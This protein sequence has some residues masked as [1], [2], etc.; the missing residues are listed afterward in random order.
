[1]VLSTVGHAGLCMAATGGLFA[2]A[3]PRYSDKASRGEV[4]GRKHDLRHS[5]L[6]ECRAMNCTAKP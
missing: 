2:C 5:S 6:A 3:P 4:Q 1:M